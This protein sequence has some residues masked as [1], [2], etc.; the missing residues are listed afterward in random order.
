M[1]GVNAR[2][3]KFIDIF[4]EVNENIDIFLI[5]DN[6]L[7]IIIFCGRFNWSTLFVKIRTF[8]LTNVI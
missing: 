5:R 3:K 8:H 2:E 1:A 4:R 6:G 7:I